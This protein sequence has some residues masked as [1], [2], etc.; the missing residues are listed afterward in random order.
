MGLQEL[1]LLLDIVGYR[2]AVRH[3]TLTPALAGSNPASPVYGALAQAVEHLTFNQVVG[4]SNPPCF[5][6]KKRPFKVSFL[7]ENSVFMR[8]YLCDVA[9]VLSLSV[10]F[11]M[12]LRN[13]LTI[14]GITIMN[15]TMG[16]ATM[17]PI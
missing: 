4:G 11:K 14:S 15:Q 12:G 8:F 2:Q 1:S 10:C 16:S 13:I 6:K 3:R 17:I 9:H 5:T 7:L